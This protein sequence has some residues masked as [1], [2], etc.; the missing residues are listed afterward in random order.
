[1]VFIDGQAFRQSRQTP[2]AIM[3]DQRATTRVAV[4]GIGSAGLGQLKQTQ[5]AFARAGRQ[6]ELVGFE[7]KDEVGGLW[8][9]VSE[10]KP[11]IRKHDDGGGRGR[12]YIYPPAGEDP[13]P[14]YENLR[15]TLPGVSH[16][17]P[18]DEDRDRCVVCD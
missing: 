6:L 16:F 9:Y 8:N 18:H 11:F 4:I 17:D 12:T 14:F 2:R 5:D 3:S 7:M 10:V 13:T 1:M 15:A